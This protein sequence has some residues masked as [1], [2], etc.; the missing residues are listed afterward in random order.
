[1]G[2]AVQV[3]DRLDILVNNAGLV[4]RASIEET[5]LELW[6]EVMAVNATGVFLGTKHALPIMR[7]GGGGSIVNIS[8]VVSRF[9][10][11][12]LCNGFRVGD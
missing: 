3:Y 5:T 4:R 11:S 8:S 9:R 7:R 12:R 6:N 10:R 1:V 2:T